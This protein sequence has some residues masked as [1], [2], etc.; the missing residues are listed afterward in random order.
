MTWD[1]HTIYFMTDDNW[2]TAKAL[3]WLKAH[4]FKPIKPVHKIGNELRYRLKDP[5]LFKRFSTKILDNKVHIVFG[6]LK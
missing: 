2:T 6:E 3:R 4:D 1:I 5:E